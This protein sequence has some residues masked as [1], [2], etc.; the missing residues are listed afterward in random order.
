V[1]ASTQSVTARAPAKINIYLGVGPR[2]AD[3]Y[4]DLATV[5]HALRLSDDVIAQRDEQGAVSVDV[6]TADGDVV[7]ISAVPRDESNLAVQAAQTLRTYAGVDCGVHLTIVKR[8]PV[9]GGLAG[10]SADAAAALV[11]CDAV[12][13][14]GCGRAELATLAARLGS[15]VPFALHGG[16]VLGS[17]RGEQLA[18]VLAPC[19]LHWVLAVA[20]G[21]LSTPEVYRELDSLRQPHHVPAPQVP[22]ELL[23]ALRR[24]DVE[25]VAAHLD[26]DLQQAAVALR[27]ALDDVLDVGRDAGAVGGLVSGSGPTVVFLAA[28]AAAADDI[29]DQLVASET[30]IAAVP[31]SGASAGARVVHT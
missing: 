19:E 4:H 25:A 26:N 2:R 9:A 5:F 8:I 1:R 24:S 10:G 30:C 21:G 12:W 23:S 28:D 20:E 29:A 13:E 7:D 15:D 11:A 22:R 16:T 6:A 17:G 3:G 27:P 31:T 14:T 18:P